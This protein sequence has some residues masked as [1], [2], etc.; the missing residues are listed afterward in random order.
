MLILKNLRITQEDIEN[1]DD[2]FYSYEALI[3]PEEIDY[4][5][6]LYELNVISIKRLNNSFPD[7]GIMLNR[8]WFIMKYFD[9]KQLEFEISK[10]I[11]NCNT[12]DT[13]EMYQKINNF[14]R[15]IE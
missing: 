15:H 10:I 3:G 9:E 1:V 5:Y 6:E 11:M 4:A 13:D 14:L 8:G 12:S 7:D 2:F